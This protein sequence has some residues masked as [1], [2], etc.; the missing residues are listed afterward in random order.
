MGNTLYPQWSVRNCRAL[1]WSFRTR[2]CGYTRESKRSDYEQNTGQQITT[3]RLPLYSSI[4][5]PLWS[6]TLFINRSAKQRPPGPLLRLLL[7]RRASS[8]PPMHM[9]HER[10]GSTAVGKRAVSSTLQC[11]RRRDVDHLPPTSPCCENEVCSKG[12]ID[13]GLVETSIQM[14]GK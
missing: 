13:K 14:Q 12:R 11:S 10:N 7:R 1:R 8:S 5:K 6:P 4:L 9:P 3:Q 2:R